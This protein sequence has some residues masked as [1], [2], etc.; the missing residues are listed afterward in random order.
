VLLMI[1]SAILDSNTPW[2]DPRGPARA[3]TRTPGPT[4]WP[5]TVD[6]T[7]M[8]TGALWSIGYAIVLV[9]LAFWHFLRKRHHELARR[10][11]AK[12]AFDPPPGVRGR[13]PA[14]DR[15]WLKL[16]QRQQHSPDRPWSVVLV[17]HE[18]M[19]PGFG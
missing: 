1:L 5:P 9:G 7:D 15:Q 12:K 17:V 18:A 3:L 2:A 4:R 10:C 14:Q 11:S 16:H 6:F 13:K 19:W 8:I